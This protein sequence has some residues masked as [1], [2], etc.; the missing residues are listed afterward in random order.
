M[1]RY[2]ALIAVLINKVLIT[3]S[4]MKMITEWR[5]FKNVGGRDRGLI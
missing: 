4:N 2:F 3:S 1:R 5:I